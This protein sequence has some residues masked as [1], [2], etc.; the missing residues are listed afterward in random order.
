[1]ALYHAFPSASTDP[2]AGLFPDFRRAGQPL[3][4]SWQATHSACRLGDAPATIRGEGPHC[5]GQAESHFLQPT[6]SSTGFTRQ[7]LKWLNN[8]N[9]A[10]I[11]H[12]T[13]Q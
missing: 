1:M 6:H 5:V 12:S 10:P 7:K 3:R 8:A 4:Q 11:G 13:R 2:S 9:P